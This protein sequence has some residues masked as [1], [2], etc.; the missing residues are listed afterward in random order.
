MKTRTGLRSLT[1]LVCVAE[2]FLSRGVQAQETRLHEGADARVGRPAEGEALPPRV[3]R[4]SGVLAADEAGSLPSGALAMMF[5]LYKEQEGGTPLW[6]EIQD[7]EP[8]EHGHYTA[9]LGQNTRDGLPL[10]LF[11]TGEARWL[12]ARALLSGERRE[13]ARV[14]LVSVP[15]ALKAAD[16]ET[17][18]GLPPSAFVRSE[19]AEGTTTTA[20]ALPSSGR[21]PSSPGGVVAATAGTTGYIAKFVDSVN[22]GNSVM[23]E[24]SGNIGLG[25]TSPFGPLHIGTVSNYRGLNLG[26]IQT[27]S[28]PGILLENTSTG[29]SVALTENAGLSLYA[30]PSTS[31]G[32]TGSDLKLVLTN[33]GNLGLGT[34]SPQG[35]LHIG[36]VGAY[37][38][39]NLGSIQTGAYPGILLENSSTNGSVAFTENNGLSLYVKPSASASFVPTD[40]KLVVSQ[41]GDVGIGT[42]TP[43]KRLSVET[44]PDLYSL[45]LSDGTVTMAAG[46]SGSFGYGWFGTIST[47]DFHL[48]AVNLNDIVINYSTGYVGIGLVPGSF[49]LEVQGAVGPS[50]DNSYTLGSLTRRWSAVYAANGTI[51]TSDA[52]LK[53]DVASLGY[54]LREVMQLRPV[55]F[56]WNDRDDGR[57]H[58]GLIAQEVKDIIPEVI[59]G[60]EDP[61]TPLG[62]NY[63]NLVP[64]LIKAVQEQ[65]AALRRQVTEVK[66]ETARLVEQI[67]ELKAQNEQLRRIVAENASLRAAYRR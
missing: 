16:A 25:T 13:Q 60:G 34:S 24:G 61:A 51:Q 12:E 42:T 27:G 57:T 67:E 8:D 7:V 65:E 49:K 58:L 9:V 2:L 29:G 44:P 43:G 36:K 46:S 62:M 4:F 18:G 22:L 31:A 6:Q 48:G 35:P 55:S 52:R 5:V 30:K 59:E 40:L 1:C 33:A 39:L 11:A 66:A 3:I 63:G 26:S 47:H 45:S 10:E 15:Y 19:G 37:R 23:F 17:V 50:A 41:A 54:G 32:F 28:Y 53:K 14:L 64:V 20:A 56:Q 21:A 38:N